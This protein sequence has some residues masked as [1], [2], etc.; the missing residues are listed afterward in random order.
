M[1]FKNKNDSQEREKIARNGKR[2]EN[3]SIERKK[4]FGVENGFRFDS[5]K[6]S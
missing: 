2:R 3:R 5:P 4:K 6:R 1:A